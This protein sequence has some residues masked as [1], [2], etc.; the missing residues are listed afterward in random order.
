MSKKNG[1]LGKG[2]DLI[3]MENNI[4]EENVPTNVKI[5]EIEPNIEQPRNQF[6]DESLKDFDYLMHYYLYYFLSLK[7]EHQLDFFSIY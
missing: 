2:L 4:E 3:F 1:G 6:N 5:S 7:N